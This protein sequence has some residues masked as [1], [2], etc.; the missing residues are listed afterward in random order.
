MSI[1]SKIANSKAMEEKKVLSLNNLFFYWEK[2]LFNRCIDI[3]E[4]E[5]L[6]STIPDYIVEGNLITF[7]YTGI[8]NDSE[9]GLITV[10]G[11]LSGVTPY[12]TL[13]GSLT[14]AAPKS[15][16][17]TVNVINTF[18]FN[19]NA[20][21]LKNDSTLMGLLNLIERYAS[22]LAHADLTFK[23]QLINSRYN[24]TFVSGDDATADSVN[25]WYSDL[26][27]GK[28]SSII[29]ESL[30]Q[31]FSDLNSSKV[32]NDLISAYN[33]TEKIL[34]AFYRDLGIRT[35]RAKTERMTESEVTED[36]SLLLVNVS[37]M[38][39]CRKKGWAEVNK[40]FNLDVKVKLN[41]R[42]DYLFDTEL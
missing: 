20:I 30:T 42:Y 29:D 13:F 39:E 24:K 6:P 41:K 2:M 17:G 1:F 3:F 11:G 28:L 15:K 18:K 36:D 7:G 31:S 38:Y 14:Y 35:P 10:T 5:N 27:E 23:C 26:Y 32:N 33:V 19:Q 25:Q 21:L 34:Y 4:Y 9:A 12:P 40:M 16:G 8:V 37:N 22:L